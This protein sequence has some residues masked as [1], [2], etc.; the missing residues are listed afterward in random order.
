[1]R[2]KEFEEFWN[3]YPKRTGNNPKHKA[4]QAWNARRK[5]GH[6][7]EAMLFGARRYAAFCEATNRTGT[8]YVQMAST[9]LGKDLSFLETWEAPQPEL[10]SHIAAIEARR[11]RAIANGE[12][13]DE[14][15]FG[16]RRFQREGGHVSTH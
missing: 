5:D 6:A 7:P 3:A 8:Q 2:E 16:L 11:K 14:D 10:P 4:R 15:I 12:D 9:F 1:M 13:P